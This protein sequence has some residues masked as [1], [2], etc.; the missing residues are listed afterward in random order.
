MAPATLPRTFAAPS[1]ASCPHQCAEVRPQ[2][3]CPHWC[4]D[5]HPPAQVEALHAHTL[6]DTWSR[7][8][9]P[10]S[11]ELGLALRS[12]ADDHGADT[13]TVDIQVSAGDVDAVVELSPQDAC[14]FALSV[15]RLAG[16]AGAKIPALYETRG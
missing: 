8:D 3:A 6:P 15:L 13:P 12:F 9:D 10:D 7:P 14:D 4:T 2:L 1:R 5:T 11:P 16:L